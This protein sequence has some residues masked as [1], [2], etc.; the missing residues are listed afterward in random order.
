MQELPFVQHLEPRMAASKEK[1][2]FRLLAALKAALVDTHASARQHCLLAYASISDAVGAEQVPAIHTIN[3]SS[4]VRS[5]SPA[6]TAMK[7][8]CSWCRQ[9]SRRIPGAS[10]L[11]CLLFSWL[12]YMSAVVPPLIHTVQGGSALSGLGVMQAVRDAIVRPL[13]AKVLEQHPSA[14]PRP[15][16]IFPQVHCG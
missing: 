8:L 5:K 12:R 9:C 13:V 1:L 11:L 16:D 14:G 4:A 2:Q 10:V 7:A 3:A 6:T 15:A